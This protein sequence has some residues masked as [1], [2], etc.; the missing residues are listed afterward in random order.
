MYS[1]DETSFAFYNSQNPN[2]YDR[3]FPML[4]IYW[5]PPF[6]DRKISEAIIKA[7]ILGGWNSIAKAHYANAIIADIEVFE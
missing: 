5:K 7:D 2:E 3:M 1:E 6:L 4:V